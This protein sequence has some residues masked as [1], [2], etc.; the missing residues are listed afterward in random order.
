MNIEIAVLQ[1]A[2]LL[3]IASLAA[4]DGESYKH[5]EK[6]IHIFR[7]RNQPFVAIMPMRHRI[8]CEICGVE[9]GES[10]FH[11]EN[12]G[13]PSKGDEKQIMWGPPKGVWVQIETAELHGALAHGEEPG[14]QLKQVLNS[15]VC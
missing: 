11:F 4:P 15:V 10:I 9:R 12:P 6:L 3:E 13:I 14:I 5:Q 1:F 8:R 7:E 2:N